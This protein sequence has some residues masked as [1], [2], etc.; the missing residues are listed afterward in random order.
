M[1]KKNKNKKK[2]KR[3]RRRRG[4]RRRGEKARKGPNGLHS[5]MK[6]RNWRRFW[7]RVRM[8]GS[9][10]EKKKVSGWSMEE[11]MEKPT[12]AVEEDTGEMK[13]WR[14]M[15]QSEIDQSW[16]NLVERMEEEVLDKYRVEESKKEAFRGG[17]AP[18]E[19]RRMRKRQ[20]NTE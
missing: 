3:Q 14:G 19:W 11:M 17:G 18:L 8:E 12:I 20:K 4:R 5:G 15:S 13:R 10:K 1:K 6:N 2:K 7:N 16:K 9:L